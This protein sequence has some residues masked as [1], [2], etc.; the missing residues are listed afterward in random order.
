[1]DGRRHRLS[2][3]TLSGEGLDQSKPYKP[4]DVGNGIVS[5]TV[6][7]NGRLH[8]LG[9][10]H[11]VIG[12]LWLTSTEPFP[13]SSRADEDAVRRHR[14]ALAA[15]NRPS[16]GLSLLEVAADA[17]LD[18][19]SVPRAVHEDENGRIEVWTV[20]PAYRT[21]LVQLIRVTAVPK[22]R[23]LVPE[24]SGR[25]RL[26]RADYT[27]ITEGGTIPHPP[28]APIEGRDGPVIWIDD[29]VLDAEVAV[30]LPAPV[31][32]GEGAAAE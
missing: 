6:A 24:W 4:L 3:P 26:G 13:E 28:V 12:R 9:M 21:G 32:L 29:R 23:L 16:F 2:D 17:F 15:R 11:P 27:Q 5:G 22:A 30:V 1:M 7:P 25:P 31:K 20:A 10:A 18:E 19:D 8:S 14:A